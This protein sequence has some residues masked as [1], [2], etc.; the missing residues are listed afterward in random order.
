MSQWAYALSQGAA[1]A[2]DSVTRGIDKKLKED[3]DARAANR[4][5]DIKMRILAAQEMMVQRAEERKRQGNIAMGTEI[6]AKAKGM[7]ASNDASAINASLGSTIDPADPEAAATLAAIRENPAAAAAYGLKD[8]TPIDRVRARGEAARSLGYLDAA[9]ESSEEER[10]LLTDQRNKALDEAAKRRDEI[11]QQ[12][13]ERQT[14]VAEATAVHQRAMLKAQEDRA[15]AA[16]KRAEEQAAANERRAT[17]EALRGANAEIKGL[18]KELANPMLDPAQAKIVQTQLNTARAEAA[19][20][21]QALAAAGLPASEPSAPAADNDPLGI[22]KKGANGGPAPSSAAAAA[23]AVA[24]VSRAPTAPSDPIQKATPAQLW[25]AASG[26]DALQKKVAIEELK[27]R[28]LLKDEAADASGLLA[29][30][31]FGPA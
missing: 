21:R 22:R 14:R 1:A 6:D 18:E 9:R 19:S 28:G 29:S 31:R 5:L 11:A 4:D 3:A 12:Q 20:Y 25:A 17:T 8:V 26:T 10:N 30:G 7:L 2:A 27:R 13:A 24:S 23:P 15:T 16:D